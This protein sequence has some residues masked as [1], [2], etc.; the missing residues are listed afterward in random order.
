MTLTHSRTRAR[1]ALAAALLAAAPAL[2]AA[3]PAQLTLSRSTPA[4]KSTVGS[5]SEIRLWFSEAPME[6]GPSSVTIRV[7]DADREVVPAGPV[8]RDRTDNK[9]FS[10]GLPEGLGPGRYTVA[11]RT[12]AND[13]AT[14]QGE[15]GFTV[16]AS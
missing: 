7:L 11:W 1:L 12:M 4:D 3:R 5:V 14:V 13:G 2:L 9:V 10:L 6:M 8:A 15:F 16:A